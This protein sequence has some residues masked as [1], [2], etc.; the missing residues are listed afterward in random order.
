ML[1]LRPALALAFALLIGQAQAAPW[2]IVVRDAAGKPLADAVVAVQV[3]NRPLK[4]TTATAWMAQKDRQFVPQLLVVQTGTQVSFPNNDTVRH[5]VYSFSPIKVFEI[6]LYA[7]TPSA[8]ITFDKP[9]VATMGCN[10]HDRMS[11]HIVVVDTP[12]FTRTDASGTARL[13]VPTGEH[14]LQVWHEQMKAPAMQSQPLT[15]TA[16]AAGSTTVTV[17]E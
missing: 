13:D 5:H 6:K 15:V 14:L 1:N 4:T 11:A 10:I 7:G 12:L 2:T 8:P 3:K 17:S 16:D 9:G